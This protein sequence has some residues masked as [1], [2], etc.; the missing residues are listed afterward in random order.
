MSKDEGMM[1]LFTA[2]EWEYN[3]FSIMYKT[4]LRVANT[5]CCQVTYN[6]CFKYAF[7]T[8]QLTTWGVG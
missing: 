8:S 1:I 5:A 7:T 4:N 3:I 6:Y 2:I